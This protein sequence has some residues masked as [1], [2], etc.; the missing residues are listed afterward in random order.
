MTVDE[1][2][3][4]DGATC[5]DAL[6]ASQAALVDAERAQ[7]ELVA[8]WCDLHSTRHPVLPTVPGAERSV[9]IGGDGTP[10]VGEFAA[11]ELG[12]LLDMTTT[13]ALW[14]MRDVLGL[15]HRHPRLFAAVR[16]VRPGSS[17]PVTSPASRG[18]RTSTSRRPGTSTTEWDRSSARS[19]G[20]G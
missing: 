16:R 3:E 8:H 13:S 6:T 19:R 14:L 7:V 4:F 20:G 10:S 9:V 5:A 2:V 1:G 12:V 15:R 17:R 11:A 18:P